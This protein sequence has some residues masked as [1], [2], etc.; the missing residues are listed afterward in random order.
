MI[1]E[2]ESA[3]AGFKYEDF[4]TN[5]VVLRAVERNFEIIGEAVKRLSKE[6]T[7]A[8]PEVPWQDIA[9]F[10]DVLIHD[11]AAVNDTTVWDTLQEDI[12]KLKEVLEKG[13]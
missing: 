2:V 1:A 3:V 4:A 8:H 6:F 10:R 11:Y 9:G 7:Q 5:R 12:P 13:K